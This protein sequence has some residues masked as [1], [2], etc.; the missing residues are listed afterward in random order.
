MSY[1][2]KKDKD[3]RQILFENATTRITQVLCNPHPDCYKFM[4][5]EKEND[6]WVYKTTVNDYIGE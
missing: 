1:W 5:W 3:G 2:N 6:Q 4:V